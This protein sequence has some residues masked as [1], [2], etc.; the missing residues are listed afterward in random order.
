MATKR[1]R[2]VDRSDQPDMSQDSG[3]KRL[4]NS[5]RELNRNE[6][7]SSPSGRERASDQWKQRSDDLDRSSGR[8]TPITEKPETSQWNQ[9]TRNQTTGSDRPGSEISERKPNAESWNQTSGDTY[10][11]SR[12]SSPN[13]QENREDKSQPNMQEKSNRLMHTGNSERSGQQYSITGNSSHA[14]EK[15][16]RAGHPTNDRDLSRESSDK[17]RSKSAT[18]GTKQSGGEAPTRQ[19]R[20]DKLLRDDQVLEE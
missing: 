5:S 3:R 16:L 9:G 10:P 20:E 2:P 14:A 7:Q 6:E 19:R 13:M 8:Q 1:N 4:T 12:K 17:S 15:N 11:T 18:K